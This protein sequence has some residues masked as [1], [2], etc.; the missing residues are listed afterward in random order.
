MAQNYLLATVLQFKPFYDMNL[1]T[2]LLALCALLGALFL[3][4]C[5]DEEEIASAE[6]EF[7][8]PTAGEVVSDPSDVHIHVHFTATSGELHDIEVMLHPEGD[9]DDMIIN[10]DE[11]SHDKEY[12]F[13][14]DRDLS[15][16]ASGTEFHLEAKAC[17]DHDCEEVTTGD[18]EFSIP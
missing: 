2:K 1:L 18:I 8:E 7:E 11:H 14:E 4:A 17:L 6:I 10:F 5:K 16:Y 13:E 3:T 9:V 12:I 15:G